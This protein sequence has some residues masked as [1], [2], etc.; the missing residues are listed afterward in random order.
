M[1]SKS[2]PSTLNNSIAHEIV[3]QFEL[4]PIVAFFL[5]RRFGLIILSCKR[6]CLLLL[7]KKFRLTCVFSYSI[8]VAYLR[9]NVTTEQI[10]EKKSFFCCRVFLCIFQAWALFRLSYQKL[11]NNRGIRPLSTKIFLYS[12]L[13]QFY[14]FSSR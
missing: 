1:L 14:S 4:L 11:R 13:Y 8:G 3:Y 12:I 10:F 5:F 2:I 6:G 7:L 9:F